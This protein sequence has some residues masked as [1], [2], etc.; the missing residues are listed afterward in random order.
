MLLLCATER[1]IS[2]VALGG[3]ACMLR[4]DLQP[5]ALYSRGSAAERL[6]VI[7]IQVLRFRQPLVQ[8][9]S[10]GAAHQREDMDQRD[11]TGALPYAFRRGG[12]PDVGEDAPI[13]E[14]DEH[15]RR[16]VVGRSPPKVAARGQFAHFP[17]PGEQGELGDVDI[18]APLE[19]ERGLAAFEAEKAAVRLSNHR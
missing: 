2:K 16:L 10:A 19:R 11:G 15:L 4:I 13:G 5:Y 3:G 6:P 8:F 18:H 7:L 12:V 17:S 1:D 14:S 9:L